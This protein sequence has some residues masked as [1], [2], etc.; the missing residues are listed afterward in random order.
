MSPAITP[1]R[2]PI[3]R[4]AEV[5]ECGTLRGLDAIFTPRSVA[6]VG[7]SER[8]GSVGRAVLENLATF[9]GEVFVVN[10]LHERVLGRKSVPALR[11][12]G[13]IPDLA[14]IAVP[15]SAVPGVVRDCAELEIP[16]AII[17]SAGFRECGAAGA[18]LERAVLA[19]A[20]GRVRLLGPNCLGVMTPHHG[21]NATFASPMALPGSVACISQSGALCAAILDWSLRERVGFSAFVS[22]GAMADVS[23]GDLIDH[24]GDDP[25]TRSIVCYME[26]VGAARAFLSAAREVAFRK[27]IVILKVGRTDAG[28]RAAASHTGALTG[29][30]EVVSAAFARAGVLRVRSVEEL[31][32]M[33]EVLARQ[34]RPAGPQLSIITNAGGPAALAAD[35]AVTSG[36]SLAELSPET[37]AA[38]HRIV[39]PHWSHG[40]PVD[41][42]GA[43]DGALYAQ[44]AKLVLADRATHG[45]LVVLTPQTMTQPRES[46]EQLVKVAAACGKPVLSC[47]MGGGAVESGR[48]VLNAAG[49]PTYDYP[50]EA[51]RAF[52][53]MWRR[54]HD[55][56][57]LYERP[58]LAPV[59]AEAIGRRAAARKLIG[60]LRRAGRTLLTE[61]EAN[62]IFAAYGIPVAPTIAARSEAEAIAAAGKIGFPVALKLW[63]ETITHKAR[64]GGVRLHLR[65]AAQV[66]AA[67]RSIRQT[68]TE[69]AGAEDF[70]GVVVQPMIEARGVEL[71]VGSSVDPQFGPVMLFGAGGSLV[72]V[73][74][75]RALALPPLNATLA[76]RLMEQT[77]IYRALSGASL[78]RV[79]EV[80]IRFS[81][82]VAEQPWIAEA[83]LNPLLVT[84][85]GVLALDARVVL[86]PRETKADALPRLAIRPYPA[87][88]IRRV[89][90]A[91]VGAVMLRP[92]RPEDETLL[93]AFHRSLSE[94]TVHQRYFG[95]IPLDSR[96]AHERLARICFCDYDREIAIVA[97][98]REK[99]GPPE[100]VA[101]G[102]INRVRGT[103]EAQ[104]A[105]LVGD[106]WQGHGVGTATMRMLV[107]VGRREG[108]TRITGTVLA[109][110]R[111]MQTVAREAGFTL[112]RSDDEFFAEI[113]L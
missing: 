77:R 110:N 65:T 51:A 112:R 70:T 17:I 92:I 78:E 91:G 69:R 19:A 34:P 5:P 101:V 33:A 49:I 22:I 3:R 14:I 85:S 100:I 55:L 35:Q 67:W 93:I 28:S 43:A 11:V 98:R 97:E 21:M 81:H 57:A 106:P 59:S 48:A 6:V 82:L 7:A 79:S 90:L 56:E 20:A 15:A 26:S 38:L 16:A 66:R 1:N 105:L 52:A 31:F 42:L 87:E 75:D 84:E 18:A 45:L 25:H 94:R 88:Y 109:T 41:L 60:R 47:W 95:N 4:R 46:A 111:A 99:N 102:R 107:D 86:Y 80:L 71:I 83:D 64:A 27:P 53:L 58:T 2:R 108:L 40:N 39:P 73:M 113:T 13:A 44:A 32:D 74:A 30:D 61:L 36:A 37:L 29:S 24:F 89:R 76:R 23:W 68:V 50:D 63:S 54:S 12:L 96:I 9:P 8:L 10:P 103:T 72:E 104:F 62:E